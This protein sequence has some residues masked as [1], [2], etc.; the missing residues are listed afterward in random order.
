M[1]YG[2]GT[3]WIRLVKKSV[4]MSSLV[5]Q[6]ARVTVRD[7]SFLGK[8][9]ECGPQYKITSTD[10]YRKY[11]RFPHYLIMRIKQP[12]YSHIEDFGPR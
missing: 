11:A 9:A 8:T 2:L 3:E 1:I 4:K 5:Q 10:Q 6:S 12:I 7:F